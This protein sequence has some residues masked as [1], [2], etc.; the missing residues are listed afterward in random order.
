MVNIGE[1]GYVSLSN[2]ENA[3]FDRNGPTQRNAYPEW[4]W[5]WSTI[6]LY[7]YNDGAYLLDHA[8][9]R[10]TNSPT[11]GLVSLSTRQDQ[12]LRAIYHDMPLGDLP[13]NRDIVALQAAVDES[14]TTIVNQ[15]K[16]R[17]FFS[18]QDM[19][20]PRPGHNGDLIGMAFKQIGKRSWE[21]AGR[22]QWNDKAL[23]DPFRN[24]LDLISFRHNLYS[25]IVAAQAFGPDGNTVVAEKRAIALVYRDAYTGSYFTRSFKWL[26]D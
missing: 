7:A 1:L 3:Y 17:P 13:G 4:K 22:T 10:P 14:I 21:N 16:K 6:D 2:R 18:F 25:L 12:V 15:T 19:F 11:Y 20:D 24:V 26:T 9:V 5:F 23:E 8:T